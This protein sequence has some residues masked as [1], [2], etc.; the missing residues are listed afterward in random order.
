MKAEKYQ[1]NMP[2]PLGERSTGMNRKFFT[3]LAAMLAIVFA[4]SLN[5]AAQAPNT[6]MYQGRLTNA[7]GTP[8]TTSTSVV[9]AV[10]AAAS[11]GSA[12]WTETIANVT[13]DAQGV[14]TVELGLVTPLPANLFDGSKRYLGIKV[15][16][17]AEMTPRQVLTSGPYSLNTNIGDG[18][19]TSAK[20]LDGT[21]ATADLA[22][23]SVNSAK[24]LDGT[25][26]T[27]DLANNA[28]TGAKV[29]D[30]GLSS[31]DM[32][33][34]P[35]IASAFTFGSTTLTGTTVAVDSVTIN[36]P[37]AGYVVVTAQGDMTLNHTLNAGEQIGRAYISTTAGT[38]DFDNFVYFRMPTGA[39][40]GP[41]DVP[42]S[43]TMTQTVTAGS[44]KYYLNADTYVGGGFHPANATIWRHHL[45]AMF[46]PTAYGTVANSVP[47]NIQ[48]SQRPDG[49]TD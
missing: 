8:I 45:V 19:V 23:G 28:V 34:E 31:A 40:S 49:K 25:I 6:I 37:T 7:A 15:A 29:A 36:F 17:D 39:A 20:I 43:I 24:I 33:N 10:Y 47:T 11:G 35:G 4:L 22:D 42:W 14:F 5:A 3:V 32:S 13:P 41:Y 38:I 21:I 48:G 1:R 27:G 2:Y 16:S 26:A 44:M 18:T 30:G 46:Y 9:F 12:I